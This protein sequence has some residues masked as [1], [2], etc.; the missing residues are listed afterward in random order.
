MLAKMGIQTTTN[1]NDIVAFTD[2]DD[3]AI[4]V[5]VKPQVFAD[6]LSPLQ[7]TFNQQLILSV[8]AGVTID[9]ISTVLDH[10]KVVRAMPNTPALIQQGATGLYASDSID[11]MYR[12]TAEAIVSVTGL[13]LW[14]ETE[15]KLHAVTAV[16]G[17]APAYFF[18]MMES[19]VKAGVE[20]G[21]SEQQAMQL[22]LQ[23][24]FGSA[25]MAV[26]S[27][28]SPTILRQKVTSPNGTT[29]EAI[30]SFKANGLDKVIAEGMKACVK[31][32][33]EM[34]NEG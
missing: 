26:S 16:S 32:S 31:R 14:V 33:K 17:S 7:G 21:L 18:Y 23:T 4:V 11:D 12:A 15:D 29:H 6:V 25:S 13:V 1:N 24:A 9:S 5:A 34:A 28:D 19:M 27:E 10:N 20:L 8:M 22:T 30:E 2:T 3:S